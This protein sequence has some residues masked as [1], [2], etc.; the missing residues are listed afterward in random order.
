MS[1]QVVATCSDY[2]AGF[3]R[4]IGLQLPVGISLGATALN[5]DRAAALPSM[6]WVRRVAVNQPT[7]IPF[8]VN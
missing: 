3:V 1:A 4:E 2:P 7:F 6:F 8:S 5:L